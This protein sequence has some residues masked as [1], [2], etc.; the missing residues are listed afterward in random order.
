MPMVH[1]NNWEEIHAEAKERFQ[2]ILDFES[3]EREKM[4]DD[5]KF[6]L[7]E[8]DAQWDSEDV[9][10][11]ANT[12]RSYL[13][14]MRSNQFTD[15]VKN[16]QRQ[17][18]PSIKISPTDEGAQEK[19][20]TR[21]QGL[22]RHIQYESIASQ[23]R[24]GAFD[25]SVEEGRGHYLVKT[26]YVEGTFNQKI[27]VVPIQDSRSVYM[28]WRRERPDYSDCEYGFI[29]KPVSKKVYDKENPD[30]PSSGWDSGKSDFW[31]NGKDIMIA[32][33]YCK[34]FKDRVLVEVAGVGVEEGQT[35]I[36]FE[37]E[38]K[39]DID[40]SRIIQKRTV[41][42]PH[43]MWFK[44][45]GHEILEEKELPFKLIPICTVIGKENIVDGRWSLKGL[46][47]DI[48]QL[49]R[50]YNFI[51]SN[52][53][54]MIAKAPRAPWVGAEGQFEGHEEE[55]AAS[56]VSEQA[57]LEYKPIAIGGAMAPPPQ[58]AQFSIDLS[59]LMQQRMDVIEDIKAIT[60]IYDASIGNRSNETSGIAIK[61]REQQGDNANFHYVDNFA[62]AINHEG[63]VINSALNIIY[64]T[65][66]TITIM[67][68]DD[69]ERL[70]QINH[71]GDPGL[72]V[73]NFNVTVSVGP[74]FN[75]QREEQA[76]GMLELSNNV[77]LVQ[78]VGSDLIVRAQDWVGKDALA[79]RLKFAIEKQF[80]GITTQV[81]PDG[82]NGQIVM[83]QQ[84]L[85]QCQQQ[86]QQMGQQSQQ[87]QEQLQKAQA[88]KQAAAAGKIQF[89]MGSL[90]LDKQRVQ[91]ESQ[92]VQAEIAIKQQ[93]LKLK[94]QQIKMD[95]MKAD[96]EATTQLKIHKDTLETDLIKHVS[97]AEHEISKMDK[98]HQQSEK[99]QAKESSKQMAEIKAFVEA[100]LKETNKPDAKAEKKKTVIKK[101]ADGSYTFESISSDKEVTR[102]TV[103]PSGD[104]Y[105]VNSA[106][107]EKE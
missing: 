63:R 43:W 66:R 35:K 27:V 83:L 30:S 34:M 38:I 10:S 42:D 52:I 107:K 71:E 100:K 26:E 40:E 32:E 73:G 48:K 19:V 15:H 53:A 90:E 87:L 104:G 51:T 7:G 50:L 58:R 74:S 8:D 81:E 23:A 55:F 91:I 59:N 57:T 3:V 39:Q 99:L 98:T 11:R 6:A 70:E 72:G 9:R 75:T 76:A 24:Q 41:K 49:L 103:K 85:Q 28:D 68:E 46:I 77:D 89:D 86:L 64:D 101:L 97:G 54:D 13:T 61:R 16:Q 80:P 20:A 88:D 60:G 4:L 84:Q 78:N 67:G 105:V 21:R 93:E 18:K 47:R 22:V 92:K 36:Y 69:E 95:A 96:L 65:K 79:D 31:D 62:M 14:V 29:V 56:N 17:N 94:D 44:M 5:K 102:G 106:S 12:K 37:D 45:N 1:K 33:Y 82:E 25:D 2:E